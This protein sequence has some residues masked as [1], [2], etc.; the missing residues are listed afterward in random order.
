[1]HYYWH[2]LV[3]PGFESRTRQ[4][5]GNRLSPFL[6]RRWT[7]RGVRVDFWRRVPDHVS[8]NRTWNR[9]H[10]CHSIFSRHWPLVTEP[11]TQKL[12]VLPSICLFFDII[13]W[14]NGFQGYRWDRGKREREK[15]RKRWWEKVRMR[16][17]ERE[18]ERE[19]EA[20]W[21]RES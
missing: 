18:R 12:E 13:F 9:W 8:R 19:T 3:D 2:N 16:D 5:F 11:E 1:M 6:S 17:K 7:S 4:N 10:E 21:M 14:P 15:E 20:E